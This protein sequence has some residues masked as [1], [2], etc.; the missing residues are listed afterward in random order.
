MFE[1]IMQNWKNFENKD[2]VKARALLVFALPGAVLL[3][4][5]VLSLF[6]GLCYAIGSLLVIVL[7]GMCLGLLLMFA[8]MMLGGLLHY[9]FFGEFNSLISCIEAYEK[10]KTKKQHER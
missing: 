3:Y 2:P 4:L 10:W 9:I 8:N 5:I 6:K 7:T 1:S